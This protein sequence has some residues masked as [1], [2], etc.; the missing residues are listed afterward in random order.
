MAITI[1]QRD[2]AGRVASAAGWIAEANAGDCRCSAGA[3]AT[4]RIL[5]GFEISQ[6]PFVNCPSYQQI[7]SLPFEQRIAT[8]R[9]SDFRARLLRD[10]DGQGMERRVA[11]WDRMF[12][13]GDPPDYEP[14]ADASVAA[15][16]SRQGRAGRSR[17]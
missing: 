5:L 11:K 4:D 6:N 12:P 17:V 9:R 3:D 2:K 10:S 13:L 15:M 1:L 14:S 16:A 8:L 7:A